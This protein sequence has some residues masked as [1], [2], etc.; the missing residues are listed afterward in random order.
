MKTFLNLLILFLSVLFTSCEKKELESGSSY[1][2]LD[3]TKFIKDGL[4]A[5]Y[6]FNGN[7]NDYS[8]NR[9][10][11]IVSN[12]TFTA[13]R[14]NYTSGAIHFNG[15]DDFLIVPEICRLFNE[16]KGTIIIWSK[17]DTL[18]MT[19]E[20]VKPVILSIVD[21]INTSFLLSNRMGVLE[22]SFGNYP[23]LGGGSVHSSINIEGFKLFIFSFTDNSITMY[24][25]ING[26]Y[27]ENKISNSKY[28]FGFKGNRKEQNLYLGKSIIETF[29]SDT[30]DNFF[31]Y[32]K[33][34]IDDLVIYDRVLTEDEI[35]L[36]FSMVKQ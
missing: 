33:G 30:F 8:G 32:F 28:S 34:D 22:Y 17:I 21:S 7:T 10:H 24:D 3:E 31:T 9:N 25:Y 36:F 11:A 6:P 23:K 4:I 2:Y 35:K 29:D 26:S 18:Q 20:Q 27:T 12:P 15:I 13:D 19:N 14:Y 5:Y 16:S 1:S